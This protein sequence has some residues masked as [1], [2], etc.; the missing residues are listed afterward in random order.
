MQRKALQAQF[1]TR[2]AGQRQQQGA[3]VAGCSIWQSRLCWAVRTNWASRQVMLLMPASL[4]FSML[5]TPL[6]VLPAVPSMLLRMQ[7]ALLVLLS[8]TQMTT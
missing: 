3:C 5:L 2:V 8:L 4:L 7:P 1:S 6:Q